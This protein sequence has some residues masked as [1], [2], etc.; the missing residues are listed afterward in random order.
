MYWPFSYLPDICVLYSLSLPGPDYWEID[1]EWDG[2]VFRSAL[3]AIRPRKKQ[4]ISRELALPKPIG[5]AN[6]A[7]RL[8]KIDGGQTQFIYPG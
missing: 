7:V 5:E 4:P 8:V 2:Q 3:Q 6:I 1:P